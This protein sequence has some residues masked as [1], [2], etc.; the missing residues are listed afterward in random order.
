ML[1]ELFLSLLVKSDLFVIDC[2][3]DSFFELVGILDL[4]LDL[5]DIAFSESTLFITC[6]DFFGYVSL[7]MLAFYYYLFTGGFAVLLVVFVA[8]FIC[9]YD[10]AYKLSLLIVCWGMETAPAVTEFILLSFS[11]SY[12]ISG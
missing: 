5:A 7:E 3:T 9:F 2:F 4:E 8:F 10:L 6:W 12:I 11:F 1:F